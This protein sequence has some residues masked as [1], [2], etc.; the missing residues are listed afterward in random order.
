MA[1]PAKGATWAKFSA[2]PAAG[3]AVLGLDE[4][5]AEAALG[6]DEAGAALGLDLGAQ[7]ADEDLQVVGG[8]AV[9]VAP[10]AVE[11]RLVGHQPAGVAHQVVEE[12]VLHRRELHRLPVQ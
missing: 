5:V 7:A 4:A 11:E 6:L 1:R 9:L 12:L 8:G 10:D 3:L 2:L